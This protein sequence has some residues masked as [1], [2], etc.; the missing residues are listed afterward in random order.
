VGAG[1][2]GDCRRNGRRRAVRIWILASAGAAGGREVVEQEARAGFDHGGIAG[3]GVGVGQP[4]GV[5]HAEARLVERIGGTVAA[6]GDA[7]LFALRRFLI[8]V[9]A[10][11]R[12]VRRGER[13]GVVGRPA[14]LGEFR[15]V[16]VRGGENL[17]R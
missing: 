4:R 17:S 12:V 10:V 1:R 15:G 13:G 14:V 8:V 2:R 6:G 3:L 5:L 9:G 16:F 7:F 11:E